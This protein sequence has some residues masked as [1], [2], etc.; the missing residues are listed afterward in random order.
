MA[1]CS[2]RPSTI[3]DAPEEVTIVEIANALAAFIGTEWRNHDSPFDA[4]LAGDAGALSG[5]NARAGPVLWRR[6]NCAPATA[7]PLLSD[8]GFH[9]LRLPQFGPGRTR[10]WDPVPRDVGR[11]GESEPAG[12]RL[13]LPH[14]DAAQ[15]GADR[16]L[17]P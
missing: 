3:S 2:W 1:R 7:G 4:Y 17:R 13:P 14:A 6:P 11:M 5:P 15:R 8:Q 10:Q 16:A 12:G 9:A